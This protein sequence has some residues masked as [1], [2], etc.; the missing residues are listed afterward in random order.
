M[1]L[2]VRAG[3]LPTVQVTPS[4]E[5]ITA[6]APL[7]EKPSAQSLVPDHAAL[8]TLLMAGTV[9]AVQVR[10]SEELNTRTGAVGETRGAN[11]KNLFKVLPT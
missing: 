10:P 9:V 3:R 11:P 6:L 1:Q 8:M 7:L 2:K 5:V 4:V